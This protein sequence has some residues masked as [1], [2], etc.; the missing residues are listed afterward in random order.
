MEAARAGGDRQELHEAIRENAMAAYAALERGETNPLS[1]LLSATSA[2][3]AMS[4]PAEV[5]SQLDPTTHVGDAPVRA[6]RLANASARNRSVNQHAKKGARSRA[7]RRRSSTKPRDNRISPS[8]SR[9]TRITAGDGA[10]R[11]EIEGKG[12]I[13]AKTTA[14]VFRL[15]EPLRRA[16][17]LHQRRRRRRQQRDARA[18]RADDSARGRDPRHR[19]RRSFAARPGHGRG[20]ILVP[21]VSSSSSKTMPTTIR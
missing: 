7:A 13:A 2:S 4:D 21:R 12:R 5:R 1:Q 11:N 15:S 17:A 9:W 6:R 16:D 20:A 3:S 14:R 18:A 19:G 8:C 10:R